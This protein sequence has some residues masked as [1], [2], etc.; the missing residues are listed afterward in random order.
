MLRL[1][2]Q[3]SRH[4]LI[5]LLSAIDPRELGGHRELADLK[6]KWIVSLIIGLFMMAE[7]YLPHG[8]DMAIVAP[9]C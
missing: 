6:R 2:L 3:H 9:C 7:M 4:W 5:L 8:W 1:L